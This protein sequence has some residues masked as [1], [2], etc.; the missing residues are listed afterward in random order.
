MMFI[1]HISSLLGLSVLV[2]STALVIWSS[3]SKGKGSGFG[4]A[5]GLCVFF[6]SLLSL[7]CIGYYS[8]KYWELGAFENPA[9]MAMGMGIHH[10]MME[11]MGNI[12]TEDKGNIETEGKGTIEENKV[13]A[14]S[15]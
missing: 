1:M 10:D 14:H 9:P 7:L 6:L 4:K 12:A 2:A 8:Y 11:H 5:I 15:H 13:H 3:P